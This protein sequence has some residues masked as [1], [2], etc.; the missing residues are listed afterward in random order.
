ML[1]IGNKTYRNLQEQVAKNMEDIDEIKKAM[2]VPYNEY[3]TKEEIESKLSEIES[4]IL[5]LHRIV[6]HWEDDGEEPDYKKVYIEY[7]STKN[8]EYTLEEFKAE[9]ANKDFDSYTA[10]RYEYGNNNNPN[11]GII[12]ERI[13]IY[14]NGLTGDLIIAVDYRDSDDSFI[15]END[16][17]FTPTSLIDY[18]N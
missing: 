16:A 2:P 18:L 12:T 6:L 9:I 11:S 8:D 7:W 17:S 14:I 5:K 13:N 10:I 3:Y 1:K 4:K 15:Y